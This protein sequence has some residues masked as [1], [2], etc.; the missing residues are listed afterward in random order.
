MG[1]INYICPYCGSG[2]DVDG[3]EQTY[4]MCKNM[5]CSQVIAALDIVTQ[6]EPA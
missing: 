1:E 5:K 2:V 3:E 6:R 4:Y